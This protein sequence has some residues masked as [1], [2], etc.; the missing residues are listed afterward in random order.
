MSDAYQLS[1]RVV[2]RTGDAVRVAGIRGLFRFLDVVTLN[3]S[4]YAN[5]VGPVGRAGEGSR[6]VATD[7]LKSA[8]R[9]S[10]ADVAMS[11]LARDVSD[12]AQSWRRTRGE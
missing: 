7:R 1:P 10:R 12:R 5:V 3:G 8:G 6:V 2:I 9:T 4:E 11:P